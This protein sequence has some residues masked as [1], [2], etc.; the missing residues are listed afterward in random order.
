MPKN[1]EGQCC[2]ARKF[3]SPSEVYEIYQK[4]ISLVVAVTYGQNRLEPR[5]EGSQKSEPEPSS[6]L[7]RMTGL[8]PGPAPT[9]LGLW[10]GAVTSLMTVYPNQLV[11]QLIAI[12]D[13]L[14]ERRLFVRIKVT[15]LIVIFDVLDEGGLVLDRSKP[16][17]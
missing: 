2:D 17:N 12:F 3:G 10:T 9:G 11:T 6:P 1:S 16:F 14:D 7:S 13:V 5:L 8:R 15:Q 4:P